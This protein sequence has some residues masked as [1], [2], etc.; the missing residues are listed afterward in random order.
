MPLLKT[1]WFE[2]FLQRRTVAEALS[3]LPKFKHNFLCGKFGYT[4]TYEGN[5][6]P[7]TKG[8]VT[9]F[10]FKGHIR[11]YGGFS[12]QKSIEY[13][14]NT[15]TKWASIEAK[16]INLNQIEYR[17]ILEHFDEDGRVTE[18]REAHAVLTITNEKGHHPIL[19][20]VFVN[21]VKGN[22]TCVF[23]KVSRLTYYL[24]RKT[25]NKRIKLK[26]NGFN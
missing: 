20:E 16:F 12:N 7:E 3:Y 11:L 5:A 23:R 14:I 26:N 21:P 6:Y 13:K 1:L 15:N 24:E 19:T 22:G 10:H 2:K 25:F 18:R 4:N 9:I 17:Y 8:Y